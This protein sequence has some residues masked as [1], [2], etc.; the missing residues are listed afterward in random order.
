MT[1]DPLAGSSI[2]TGLRRVLGPL[3]SRFTFRSWILLLPG[4]GLLLSFVGLDAGIG[5]VVGG[6]FPWP[7]AQVLVMVLAM[8]VP[9]VITGFIPA[10]RM[11]EIVAVRALLGVPLPDYSA[12]DGRSW[13]TRWRTAAWFLLHLLCGGVIALITLI[14]P[15]F[16]VAMMI[17]PLVPEQRIK[18]SDTGVV[19]FP[20]GAA[21]LW[22]VPAGL[23]LFACSLYVIFWLGVLLR[24]LAPALLGPSPEER[25][26]RLERRT[27]QLAERNR[28]AR[29]LHD[30]V[31]HALTVTTVQAGAARLVLDSDPEFVR[32]ALLAIEE[33][34]R[35]AL[36]D[37]D[38]VLGLLREERAAGTT[39]QRTLADIRSLLDKP[40][41]QAELTGDLD[42]VRPA[43]SREAY[44]IVQECL[45]NALRH[46][47]EVDVRVRIAVLDG[48]LELDVANPVGA[49]KAAGRG[50]RG[51]IGMRER[52]TVLG[53][54]F[55]A[56][57]DDGEWRVSVT[58]PLGD[59]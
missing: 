34:G 11:V 25:I 28:L 18:F 50:G 54:R 39:P 51:L 47:G 1:E 15:T 27:E 12:E 33:A 40:R 6:W 30:S 55:S 2:G 21:A 41:V 5:T 45:T 48:V 38:H 8:V 43:V 52:V 58:L 4:G 57:A 20:S 46:A 42:R 36:E 19:E 53:G 24:H 26:A 49:A 31:G 14:A 17:A 23:V 59:R 35:A 44:R 7:P 9:P 56:G 3:V 13:R 16:G 32:K 37:L 22:G 10:V 29:E